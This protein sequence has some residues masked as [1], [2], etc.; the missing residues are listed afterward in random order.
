MAITVV[1]AVRHESLAIGILGIIGGYT[2]PILVSSAETSPWLLFGYLTLLTVGVL[3]VAAHCKWMSFN[4]SSF[5]A[6][7]LYIFL[8]FM[9]GDF[10]ENLGITMVFLILIFSLYLGV[11]SVYNIKN[12]KI[13]SMSDAIL[14]GLNA[15]YFFLWGQFLLQ[16]T[17][18][19]DYLG[20]YAIAMA[21]I[22][23]LLGKAAHKIFNEDKKQ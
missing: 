21:C 18:L 9:S 1:L 2:T 14:V 5:F 3:G 17:F 4:Y 12:K 22:Y 11:S 23:V 6:N 19:K 7:Q 16:E 8:W 10:K 20:F 15:F 13:S